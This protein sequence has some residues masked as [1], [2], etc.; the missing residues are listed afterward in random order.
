MNRLTKITAKIALTG[1]LALGSGA[2]Y[3]AAP[4]VSSAVTGW[5]VYGKWHKATKTF[6]VYHVRLGKYM[7]ASRIT[8]HTYIKKGTYLREHYY[9]DLGG[10]YLVET[11]HLHSSRHYIYVVWGK[12]WR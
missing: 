7:A 6:R 5:H 9:M 11:K 3:V 2:A 12:H 8:S 4:S 1:F 10:G